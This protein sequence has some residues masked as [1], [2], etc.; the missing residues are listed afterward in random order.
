MDSKSRKFLKGKCSG[1]ID[2]GKQKEITFS[3]GDAFNK[4]KKHYILYLF[5]ALALISCK[6]IPGTVKENREKY[7][8]IAKESTTP[9]EL[10]NVEDIYNQA[11]LNNEEAKINY[12]G[13]D[14]METSFASKNAQVNLDSVVLFGK[15]N[16][17]IF[18]DFKIKMRNPEYIK[19]EC[20][21]RDFEVIDTRLYLG[22]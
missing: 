4:F 9:V 8:Q 7:L 5:L 18:Y 6:S 12:L 19:S 11:K 14:T 13:I 16:Y 21:L 15:E 22:R 1:K 17:K 10:T 2:L 3:H 20:R